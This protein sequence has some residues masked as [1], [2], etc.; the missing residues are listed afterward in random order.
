MGDRQI[1]PDR[2]DSDFGGAEIGVPIAEVGISD[3]Q[4]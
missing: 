2:F 3:D 1:Q 4:R